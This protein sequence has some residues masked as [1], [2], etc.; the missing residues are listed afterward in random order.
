[1]FDLERHKQ[2]NRRMLEPF[3]PE[4]LGEHPAVDVLRQVH[5]MAK[6]TANLLDDA[7]IYGDMPDEQGHAQYLQSVAQ[8]AAKV[9]TESIDP[10]ARVIFGA[11]KDEKLKKNEIKVTVIATGF[12]T[13]GGKKNNL[14]GAQPNQAFL[15]SNARDTVPER[16]EMTN[17]M[18][19]KPEIRTEDPEAIEGDGTE[20]DWG[21]IP[22]FLRRNKK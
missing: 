4:L 14:F 18:V 7:R 2:I 19:Q 17:P 6:I 20:E 21:A 12:P 10:N 16:K 11:F 1:M 8:D 3:P 15:G 13:E 9:I 22:A 5:R